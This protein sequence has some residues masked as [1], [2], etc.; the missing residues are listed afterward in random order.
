LPAAQKPSF[1]FVFVSKL[2][3]TSK[4]FNLK[5]ARQRERERDRE[6]D[7]ERERQREKE[8]QGWYVRFYVN[9]AKF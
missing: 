8:R 7:R 6:R 5:R 3:P 1:V 2:G 4:K 9:V